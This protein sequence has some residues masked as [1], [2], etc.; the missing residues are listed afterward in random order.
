M[1]AHQAARVLSGGAGLFAK[2]RRGS[3]VA[4]RQLTRFENLAAA[5]RGQRHLARRDH[6][7]IGFGIGKHRV[8]EFAQLAGRPHRLARYQQ[9][10]RDLKVTAIERAIEEEGRERAREAR[11]GTGEHHESAARKFCGAREIEDAQI[12]AEF[13][14]R[15]G[16][17]VEVARLAPSAQLDVGRFVGAVGN[18]IVEKVW[19]DIEQ[20]AQAASS[21]R[22]ARER[23][24]PPRARRFAATASSSCGRSSRAAAA[25]S[26]ASADRRREAVLFGLCAFDRRKRRA[27]LLVVAQKLVDRRRIEA[28]AEERFVERGRDRAE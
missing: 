20:R 16:D 6:E 19:H 26:L 25:L 7:K 1:Q 4:L 22:K 11:T 8:G 13:P 24:L 2:A 3:D 15:F 9:R 12:L 10:R 23:A 17:E 5:Q 28:A 27:V 18:R 14:M 21:R